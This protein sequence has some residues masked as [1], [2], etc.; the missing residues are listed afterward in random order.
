[1][2]E[3]SQL[4]GLFPLPLEEDYAECDQLADVGEKESRGLESA[5]ADNSQPRRNVHEMFSS[6]WAFFSF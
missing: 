2:N 4:L 3:D 1:M 5:S 6:S